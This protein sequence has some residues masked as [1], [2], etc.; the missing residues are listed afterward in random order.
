[1]DLELWEQVPERA[2]H[3]SAEDVEA[4]NIHSDLH[5]LTVRILD[6]VSRLG[7]E[8]RLPVVLVTHVWQADFL[9]IQGLST[10]LQQAR[11]QVHLLAPV[12]PLVK[13]AV[14]IVRGAARLAGRTLD[15][16]QELTDG[17]WHVSGV[18]MHD[19][20]HRFGLD[21]KARNEA[22][23][24]VV[25]EWD[26]ARF[27]WQHAIKADHPW[28]RATLTPTNAVAPA[29]ITLAEA[30][31]LRRQLLNEAANNILDLLVAFDGVA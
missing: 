14:W 12:N 25:F 9:Q 31:R 28:Q 29:E 19:R 17:C 27:I 6:D 20:F 3:L 11:L 23:T 30:L 2:E 21:V 13:T 5:P 4:S 8:T 24:R 15:K 10:D 16:L 18:T 1:M 7:D 26:Q 22:C